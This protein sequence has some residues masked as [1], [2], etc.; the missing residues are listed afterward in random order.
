MAKTMSLFAKGVY[1]MVLDRRKKAM[2]HSPLDQKIYL[3][4]VPYP[5]TQPA[6]KPQ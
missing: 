2:G 5:C 6:D 4:T 3:A 1:S